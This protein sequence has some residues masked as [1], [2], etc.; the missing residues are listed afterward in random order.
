P[1]LFGDDPVQ[2]ELGLLV[3]LVVTHGGV[4]GTAVGADGTRGGTQ[5]VV[6]PG[7]AAPGEVHGPSGRTERGGHATAHAS[8]G[9]GHQCDV[10]TTGLVRRH[11]HR[12]PSG[13]CCPCCNNR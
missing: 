6:G 8:A 12:L 9:A 10:A 2:H 3:V 1:S 5:P 4:A 7:G 13:S 11:V